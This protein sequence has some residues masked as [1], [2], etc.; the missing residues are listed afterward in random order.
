MPGL[1]VEVTETVSDRANGAEWTK[2]G[3]MQVQ[4]ADSGDGWNWAGAAKEQEGLRDTGSWQGR[5]NWRGEGGT[6]EPGQPG[7]GAFLM[8]A[9]VSSSCSCYGLRLHPLIH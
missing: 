1:T 9:I 8:R 6:S 7:R 3:K 5:L 4:T 2:S